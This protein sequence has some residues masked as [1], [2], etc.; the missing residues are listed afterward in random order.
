MSLVCPQQDAQWF[1][2][3]TRSPE[4]T[5]RTLVPYTIGSEDTRLDGHVYPAFRPKIHWETVDNFRYVAV[6]V[7]PA[8]YVIYCTRAERWRGNESKPR[9]HPSIITTTIFAD[10]TP[11]WTTYGI[12]SPG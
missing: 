5:V 10:L 8:W 12:H 6:T 11:T 7:S 9:G 1:L 3:S 4:P 2:S